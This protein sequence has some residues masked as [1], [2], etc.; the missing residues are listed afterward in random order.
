MVTAAKAA[1]DP[2]KSQQVPLCRRVGVLWNPCIQGAPGLP[3]LCH[4]V[5]PAHL[6]VMGSPHRDQGTSISSLQWSLYPSSAALTGHGSHP[7]T[8]L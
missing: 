5:L 6:T 4:T 7:T 3:V 2:H 8:A 1:S